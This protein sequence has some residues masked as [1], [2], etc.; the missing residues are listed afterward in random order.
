MVKNAYEPVEDAKPEE[1]TKVFEMLKEICKENNKN[2]VKMVVG[3][4]DAK[5]GKESTFGDVARTKTLHVTISRHRER[6]CDLA[7]AE[8]VF[9]VSER[10]RHKWNN[11]RRDGR[12]ANRCCKGRKRVDKR[13]DG[14]DRD[15]QYG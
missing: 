7:A 2:D 4:F 9:I 11:I 13:K 5:I 1:K 6:L 8:N 12:D 14:G 10:F 3:E 15:K